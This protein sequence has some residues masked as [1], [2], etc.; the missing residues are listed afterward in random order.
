MVPGG[1]AEMTGVLVFVVLLLVHATNEIKATRT[2]KNSDLFF[3]VILYSRTLVL[4]L[5]EWFTGHTILTF[6]PAAEVNKLTPFRTEWTKG[7]VFPLDRL[8]AGW[9]FHES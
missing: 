3:K 6:N 8:T 5:G 7:I 2:H 4:S 1:G 9:A